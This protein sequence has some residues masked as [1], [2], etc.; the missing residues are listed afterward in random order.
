MRV[1]HI[2]GKPRVRGTDEDL[3]VLPLAKVG[4]EVAAGSLGRLDT[5]DG[6]IG[7]NVVGAAGQEVVNILGG[8]LDIALDIHGET[9]GLRNG[10]TEVESDDTGHATKTDENAPHLVD[11]GAGCSGSDDRRLVGG[12]DNERDEGSG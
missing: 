11:L 4:H 12:D 3:E 5:L 2:K 9:R 7:V 6:G 1:A 10:E 8:L